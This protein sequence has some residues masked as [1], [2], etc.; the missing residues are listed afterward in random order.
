MVYF[1]LRD[2]MV[3]DIAGLVLASVYRRYQSS[4]CMKPASVKPSIMP[5][6]AAFLSSSDP[7]RK[8]EKSMSC[9]RCQWD[10]VR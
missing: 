1:V 10:G 8:R 7:L 5:F 6:A 4:T 2:T 3:L 9:M